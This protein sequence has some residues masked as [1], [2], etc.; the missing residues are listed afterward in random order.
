MGNVV[1]FIL[2]IIDKYIYV[3]YGFCLFIILIYVRSFLLARRDRSNSTF[4]IERELAGQRML[5]AVG[6]MGV[7]LALAAVITAIK[8]LVLPGIDITALSEPT[9]TLTLPAATKLYVTTTPATPGPTTSVDTA[10]PRPIRTAP[11][12][13][14]QETPTIA[15][16]PTAQ[17][18]PAACPDGDV[19]IFS[20]GMDEVVSGQIS[21][22]GSARNAQFQFYKVE[23]SVSDQ[24]GEW[25][26][27]GDLHRQPVSEGFLESLNTAALPNGTCWLQLSVVDQSGN[28]PPPCRVRIIIRN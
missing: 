25:R 13:T 15:P 3:I 2:M 8:L 24:P 20:P 9:A 21:I 16:E 28:F 26:V 4:T 27:I 23:I 10:T 22:I 1:S 18:R 17:P 11:V 5:R 19:Q 6:G 7:L 14:P 12:A